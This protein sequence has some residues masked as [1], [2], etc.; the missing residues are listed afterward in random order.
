MKKMMLLALAAA[1]V[2]MFA[3]PAV[4][5]AHPWHLSQTSTF[6]VSGPAG[7]LT[8]TSGTT[9]NCTSTKGSGSFTT[10]TGGN[11]TLS[12][13]GCNV[14]G[15]PCTSANQ[16]SGTIVTNPAALAF[17]AIMIANNT[18]GILITPTSATEV[19][20]GKKLFSEFNCFGLNT[21]VFGTGVIGTITTPGCGVASTTAGLSFT[22]SQAGHQKHLTWTGKTYDLEATTPGGSVHT[23]ASIDATATITFPAARSITCTNTVA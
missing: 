9:V 7:N 11:V 16:P 23:T 13:H 17:D 14:G 21:K 10:T 15:L 12:F 19:T 4:A 20:P 22:S 8:T 1:S 2:A 6:T 18:P 3:L 5:S